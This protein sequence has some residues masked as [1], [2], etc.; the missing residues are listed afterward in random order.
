MPISP[1]EGSTGGGCAVTNTATNLADPPGVTSGTGGVVM[2]AS[3]ATAFPVA[4]S[5]REWWR[6][7]PRR[8]AGRRR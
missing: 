4:F 5:L 7:P 3:T 2:T 1:D 8:Y 6:K